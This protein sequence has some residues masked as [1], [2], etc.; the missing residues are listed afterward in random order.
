MGKKIL[1]V[2]PDYY[3][4]FPPL[5]LLKLASY[6]REKGDEILKLVRGQVDP[7]EHTLYDRPDL[8]YVTSLFTYSWRNVHEAVQYY[9]DRYPN[10]K[11]WLGG[12]YASIWPEHAKTSGADFVHEG[13]FHEV[14][15]YLPAYDLVDD[16]WNGSILFSS[17]GCIRNCH[18]CAVPKIE[19]KHSRVLH[20]IRDLIYP[21]HSRVILFDNNILGAP[22]WRE[23]L[24]E[25]YEIGLKVDFNQGLDARLINDEVA[26]KLSKLKM[27][28]IRIAYDRQNMGK[29]VKNAIDKLSNYGISPR[30]IVCYMMY[31]FEDTPKDIF[32]RIR[33]LL[34]WGA[35]AYPMRY[36]PV[37]DPDFSLKKNSYISP[38]WNKE[39]LQKIAEARRIVGFAGTFPPY[40][41]LVE[42]FNE[43]SN[44]E[45]LIFEKKSDENKLLDTTKKSTSNRLKNAKPRYNKK[46]DWR[47]TRKKR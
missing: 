2:E 8:I 40:N 41:K 35:V 10:V 31:N 34:T 45:E 14:E 39:Q 30:K 17:R 42:R 5:G 47:K 36:Q 7:Y 11:L 16:W 21:K 15:G 46:F 4:R 9:K 18:Y 44:F 13:I 32:E 28:F 23:I 12:I 38:N 43:T 24:D 1:L 25:L 33:K 6:H 19:G 37:L 20:T 3:T 27:Q 29:S 22:N 26:E